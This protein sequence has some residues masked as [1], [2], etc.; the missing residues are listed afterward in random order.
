MICLH[1]YFIIYIYHFLIFILYHICYI[2]NHN[3]KLQEEDHG[4]YNN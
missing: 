4:A 2:L 1:E 3:S